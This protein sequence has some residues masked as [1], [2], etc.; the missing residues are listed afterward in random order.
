MLRFFQGGITRSD[1]RNMRPEVFGMYVDEM[2]LITK[3]E[4]GPEKVPVED[5]RAAAM[6][7]PAIKK[8]GGKAK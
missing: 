4:Q 1:I 7:D 3:L 5:V 2:N 6:S 8:I